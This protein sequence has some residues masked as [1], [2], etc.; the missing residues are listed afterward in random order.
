MS[1]SST[2]VQLILDQ[3]A[4]S[5]SPS[6]LWTSETSRLWYGNS[7]GWAN[8]TN[9]TSKGSFKV[10]FQ[11]TDIAFFGN[12]PPTLYSQTFN[13]DIDG[14]SYQMNYPEPGTNC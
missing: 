12:I 14:T 3:T 1:S 9:Q 10:D 6:N 7:S 8:G 11:G 5:F 2:A 4:M 13:V